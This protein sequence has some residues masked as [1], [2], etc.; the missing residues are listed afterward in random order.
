[1]KFVLPRANSFYDQAHQAPF[2]PP[3]N[4]LSSLVLHRPSHRK[5]KS[6]SPSRQSSIHLRV[7][8]KPVIDSTPLLF[9]QHHLQRLASILLRP[10][11]LTHN[12]N[13]VY[14]IRQDSVVDGCQSTGS[15]TLL[16]LRSTGTV[17]AFRSGQDAAR[18][19]HYHVPVREFLFEFASKTM[20]RVSIQP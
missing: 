15:R 14:Q 6:H 12:L 11:P 1:M 3:Y 17:R 9:I 8:I 7:S 2:S 20:C 16:S 13:R 5:L 4:I 10:R 19:K 18:G